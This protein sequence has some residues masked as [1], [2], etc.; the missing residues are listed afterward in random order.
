MFAAVAFAGQAAKVT[1]LEKV[2]TLLKDLSAK[3]AADGARGARAQI[4]GPGPK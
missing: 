2:I 1:P 4:P 3:V